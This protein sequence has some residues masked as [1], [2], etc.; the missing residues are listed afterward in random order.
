MQELHT[1]D[2]GEVATIVAAHSGET[3]TQLRKQ[4]NATPWD[5]FRTSCFPRAE[6]DRR[7]SLP[8]MSDN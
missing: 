7:I 2:E 5:T 1:P 8:D 6:R 3:W 4:F